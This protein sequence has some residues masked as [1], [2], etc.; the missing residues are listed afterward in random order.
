MQARA[1][2][3]VEDRAIGTRA[4]R[5]KAAKSARR[6]M[7]TTKEPSAQQIA[8]EV[9]KQTLQTTV[10]TN[11][12]NIMNLTKRRGKNK[13]QNTNDTTAMS[14]VDVAATGNNATSTKTHKNRVSVRQQQREMASA[15][16]QLAAVNAGTLPTTDHIPIPTRAMIQAA[17]TAM[18]NAGYIFP[19]R[20]TLHVVPVAS[21]QRGGGSGGGGGN[22]NNNN[23]ST[24][25]NNATGATTAMGRGGSGNGR[26]GG[27]N[28]N[29]SSS[30]FGGG[31]GGGRRNNTNMKMN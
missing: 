15:A 18:I 9:Q 14:G 10:R 2:S 11:A 29:G 6:G 31:G 13:T 19:D 8:Q 5:S 22:P 12:Q 25:T 16:K 3:N 17:K 23:N 27:N 1:K 28:T 26:R 21:S 20:T 24:N 4:A 30:N 7:T